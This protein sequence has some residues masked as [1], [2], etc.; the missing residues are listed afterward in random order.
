MLL[1]IMSL[2][3]LLILKSQISLISLNL[4]TLIWETLIWE[5]HACKESL[6]DTDDLEESEM[7]AYLT[8]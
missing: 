5:M 2:L 6:R 3:Q 7:I 1:R 4:K 8:Q